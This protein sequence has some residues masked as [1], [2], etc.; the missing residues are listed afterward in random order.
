MVLSWSLCLQLASC[1]LLVLIALLLLL[2]LL[3]QSFAQLLLPLLHMLWLLVCAL[4]AG[5]LLLHCAL[6]QQVYCLQSCCC[7]RSFNKPILTSTDLHL[8]IHVGLGS[9]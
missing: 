5:Q 2:A 9:Y 4:S 1:L 7:Y 6:Q 8:C 3:G